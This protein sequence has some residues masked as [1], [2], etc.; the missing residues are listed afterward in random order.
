MDLRFYYGW[1]K[2]FGLGCLWDYFLFRK[3]T[4]W[5]LFP[6]ASLLSLSPLFSCKLA[7]F[8]CTLCYFS[9]IFL[10]S[11]HC[12]SI[13]R[14]KSGTTSVFLGLGPVFLFSSCLRLAFMFITCKSGDCFRAFEPFFCWFDWLFL[15]ILDLLSCL[16]S[17]GWLWGWLWYTDDAL[18]FRVGAYWPFDWLVGT[19]VLDFSLDWDFR[20]RYEDCLI[21]DLRFAQGNIFKFYDCQTFLYSCISINCGNYAHFIKLMAL[22]FS[23][24]RIV[25]F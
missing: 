4:S 19:G 11:L 8:P 24:Y 13:F 9:W 21:I 6:E 15:L 16:L 1:I 25:N 20:L 14:I 22:D 10:S 2:S 7:L 12:F 3:C 5:L 18:A 23:L 17:F